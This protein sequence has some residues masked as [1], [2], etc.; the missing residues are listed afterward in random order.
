MAATIYYENDAD[1][2]HLK[3]KKIAILGY[4]SQGHA[5]AREEVPRGHRS[6]TP[7]RRTRHDARSTP[8]F[9]RGCARGLGLGLMIGA[10]VESRLAI[11]FAA[12]FAAGLGHFRFVDLDTAMFVLDDPFAGGYTQNGGEMRIDSEASGHG[13]YRL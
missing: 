3:G 7:S 10:M 6:R 8:G 2:S 12:H 13:V 4:G 11:A 9:R 5:Q 1:L